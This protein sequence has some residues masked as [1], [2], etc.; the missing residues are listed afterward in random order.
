MPA[1]TSKNRG[2]AEVFAKI[3]RTSPCPLQNSAL[4]VVSAGDQEK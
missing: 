3:G 4:S 1:P 2:E